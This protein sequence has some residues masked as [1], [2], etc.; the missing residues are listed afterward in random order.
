MQGGDCVFSKWNITHELGAARGI[1]VGIGRSPKISS[2]VVRPKSPR[3]TKELRIQGKGQRRNGES[4]QCYTV[5]LVSLFK[6]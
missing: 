4:W 3:E 6:G 2:F 1:P 5:L